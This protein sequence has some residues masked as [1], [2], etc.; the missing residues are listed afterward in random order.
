MKPP[1]AALLTLVAA[2]VAADARA[3]PVDDPVA[4][5]PHPGPG[6]GALAELPRCPRPWSALFEPASMRLPWK[7]SGDVRPA[8]AAGR[9]GMALSV[10]ALGAGDAAA[11]AVEADATRY[12]LCVDDRIA[13][14][15]PL[16][17][18][19]DAWLAWRS[20][21]A[22]P[23]VIEVPHP[24]ADRRTLA[25]GRRLFRELG[26]RAL[27]IAGSHRCASFE[28]A[29]CPG[30]SRVCGSG[31]EPYRASDVAHNNHS[32]FHAMHVALADAH[33]EAW[34]VSVHGMARP[35]AIISD[36]T[37]YQT[38]PESF[39]ARVAY[40]L[41]A[42]APG[43]TSCNPL[44]GLPLAPGLCGTT[45]VQGR[46]LN[47]GHE[48]CHAEIEASSGRFVHL[49]QGGALRR[50]PEPVIE[51]LRAALIAAGAIAADGTPEEAGPIGPPPEPVAM[52]LPATPAPPELPDAAPPPVPDAGP[53]DAAPD[54]EHFELDAGLAR[55]LDPVGPI[56]PAPAIAEED[57]AV[58]EDAAPIPDIGPA[59]AAPSP[60][61]PSPTTPSPIAP[62]EIQP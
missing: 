29:G 41:A 15:R 57:A 21:P 27:L 10:A 40:A 47:G 36:G 1:L 5:W 17:G 50:R 38:D 3:Q 8:S 33:P 46:H 12:A 43:V 9:Q 20:G 13:I 58:Y 35:G 61:T 19:G 16:D 26:A 59:D 7:N 11:A 28:L 14:W 18:S 24:L 60:T 37:G 52:D 62:D 55:P 42:R 2:L 4:Q 34:F 45:N 32:M 39:V 48:T 23:L 31:L 30:Q 44:V 49:E 51:A 6:P 22:A 53:A 56:D 54:V 25:Q